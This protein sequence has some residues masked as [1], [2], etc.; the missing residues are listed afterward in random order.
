MSFAAYTVMLDLYP[1]RQATLDAFLVSLG[2]N[3]A[4]SISDPTQPVGIG[5]AAAQALL[6]F[7]H[8]D[9]SNQLGELHAGAPIPTTRDSSRSMDRAL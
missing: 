5:R 7:R 6:A 2:L 8:S 4:E 9:G 3:P 1:A